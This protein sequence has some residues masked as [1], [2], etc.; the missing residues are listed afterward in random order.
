MGMMHLLA[1]SDDPASQE[2]DIFGRGVR[3]GVHPRYWGS[4]LPLPN[5]F[6]IW[7]D[8]LAFVKWLAGTRGGRSGDRLSSTA[9]V[10]NVRP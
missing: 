2:A 7:I 5:N 10:G 6:E 3:H 9:P 4:T 1:T 8:D